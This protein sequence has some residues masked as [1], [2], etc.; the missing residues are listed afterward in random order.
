MQ[1]EDTEGDLIRE[2]MYKDKCLEKL[3][4]TFEWIMESSEKNTVG[5]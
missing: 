1:G 3:D 5:E 4:G 2:E